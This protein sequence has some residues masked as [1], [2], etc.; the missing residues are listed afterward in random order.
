MNNEVKKLVDAIIRDDRA[1][2]VNSL[3]Q[4]IGVKVNNVIETRKIAA[5]QAFVGKASAPP[6]KD[7]N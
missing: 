3:K 2:S 5:S 6:A 4:V 7:N 1:S